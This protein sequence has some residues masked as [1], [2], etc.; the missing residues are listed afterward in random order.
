[1]NEST[2]KYLK[3]FHA[4]LTM[5]NY[6]KQTIACYESVLKKFLEAHKISPVNITAD[7]LNLLKGYMSEYKPSSHLLEGQSEARYSY[8]SLRNVVQNHMKCSPHLLRHCYAT[9]LREKGM[10]LAMISKLLGHKDMR[11]SLIYDHMAIDH[12]PMT[13]AI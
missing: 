7:M 13:L 8:T 10:D 11:T 4:N 2:L 3:T 12:H 6:S 5:K 1:M 9:H